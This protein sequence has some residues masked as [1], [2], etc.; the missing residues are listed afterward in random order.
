MSANGPLPPLSV[1]RFF[2]YAELT[3]FL[4][5]LAEARPGLCQL[6]SL[7]TSREGRQLHLVTITDFATGVPEDKPAYLIH[8]N[9][10]ATELAGTHT[11]LHTA[12]RLLVDHP[13]SDLL[14]RVAF[15]IVPRINPDGAEFAVTTGGQIR[16]RTD[17]SERQPN[18]LYQED[19]DGDG[20]ILSL[21]QEHP[22]GR[23][24]VDPE[25]PRLM[26]RRR[27]R[28]PGPYYRLFPE[29][30]IH[31]W[32]GSDEIRIEG[33]G[34]DWN[35]NWSY[36]W[37]PEPEQP[38]AGDFP[39][40]EPEMRA[41]AEFMHSRPNLFGVLGYHTGP[42]AVLRP[43]STGSRSDLDPEDDQVMEDLAL[44][45]AR[46]T[47]F[48]VVPVVEYHTR[49]GRDIN[50]RG[51]FHN[52]GYQ[53]LGLFVYEFEL[54]TILN[55]AGLTTEEIFAIRTEEESEAHMRRVMRWWDR[56]APD[57]PLFR[58]WRPLDHPQLGP[59]EVGGLVRP[60]TYNPS[61]R[62]LPRIA[63]A[64]YRFTLEHAGMHPWVHLEEVRAEPVGGSVYRVRAR[65]AN[66]G[67]LPTQVSNR[68][69][70]LRRLRTVQV[71]LHLGEGVQ[72]LSNRG[73]ADLGHLEG[74][75]GSRL[76]EWFVAAPEGAEVLC[77][78]RVLG[79][80]GG[81]VSTTV[82]AG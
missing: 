14:E 33:R 67:Q 38:G 73:H 28:S 32:D 77:Q 29:G 69:K 75:T 56:E 22:D 37:R 60:Y 68:G 76:L 66:R 34:F 21:R 47:G 4:R 54:G 39:F 72:L 42:A 81:N 55:S 41:L 6:S 7:G 26:V 63:E 49:R 78:V 24:V 59:V 15:Y 43:P 46:E 9:I 31:Q 70:A 53:H 11:A 30:I 19:V 80:A 51:H 23:F 52:F 45:G 16:S 1:D 10:H 71:E 79:G 17:R 57:Y 74:V 65:V 48:P 2:T 64:T 18:T 25:D 44:I 36:D 27:A 13:T 50:L 20:Y 62:H 35:R 82:C 58:P 5:A 12:R 8:G 3:D 61:L 40:S